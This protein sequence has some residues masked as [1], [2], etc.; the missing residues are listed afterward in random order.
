LRVDQHTIT[1]EQ[2]F[3]AD[4]VVVRTSDP[5]DAKTGLHNW[6]AFQRSHRHRQGDAM[7][8]RSAG[9]ADTNR[10]TSLP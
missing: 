4:L 9:E 1:A 10:E 8:S 2:V 7:V 6:V 5:V 3:R